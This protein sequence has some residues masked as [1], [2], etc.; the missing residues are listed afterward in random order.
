[1]A[2]AGAARVLHVS[3]TGILGG[4]ERS[5]LT[6][7]D[8]LDRS[9]IAGV[10]CPDGA[11]ADALRDRRLPVH[12]IRGTTASLRVHPVRTPIAIAEIIQTG[13]SL[14]AIAKRCAATVVHANSVRAGLATAVAAR[15]GAPPSV[16]H[17][18]D[19][20]PPGPAARAITRAVVAQPGAVVCISH[21]V[22][23]RFAA[24]GRCRLPVS[25]VPNAVDLARFDPVRAD[26]GATRA[27]LALPADAPVLAIVG[28]ITPWK[29]HD[30]AV[31]ALH[32]VRRTHPAARLLIV[33]DVKFDAPA[34]RLRNRSYLAELRQLV[35]ALGLG[36][37]VRFTGE[38]QDV[39]EILGAVDALL[40]PSVA[41]PF[42]RTVIE[43]MAM[44]AP[45]IATD[46]GGPAEII[47]HGV[48]GLLAPPGEPARWAE[49]VNR[50]LADPDGARARTACGRAVA[51]ESFGANRHARAMAAILDGAA[52]AAH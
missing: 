48:T 19:V 18:R 22:A 35:D 29:G 25:V 27:Q 21:Y 44:G 7:L 37:A 40:V 41:E 30:T 11:L 50:V 13:V 20:L 3:H 26:R 8:A 45:V 34:T 24:D 14:S 28:Q 17:V 16:I 49:A 6:L 52:R 33:G 1:M 43:A 38:R 12:R 2:D 46:L 4:A 47:E 10:A 36:D 31:R 32:V 23:R 9:R 42:G 15:W 39:A 5:L 51:V